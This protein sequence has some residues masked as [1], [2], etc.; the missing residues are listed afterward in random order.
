MH[1]LR[2]ERLMRHALTVLQGVFPVPTSSPPTLEKTETFKIKW[3]HVFPKNFSN[4]RTLIKPCPIVIA[5]ES[6][7]V[8]QKALSGCKKAIIQ[9]CYLPFKP[10][11]NYALGRFSSNPLDDM[12]PKDISSQSG[13]HSNFKQNED[14]LL[15]RGFAMFAH[16]CCW[17]GYKA[18]K[19]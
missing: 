17:R 12:I 8:F 1:A 3:K 5:H 14:F 18:V 6:G 9:N 2:S 16:F 10:F 19:S 7:H 15:D 13:S 4:G 11:I